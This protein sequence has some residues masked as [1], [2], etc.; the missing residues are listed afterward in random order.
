VKYNLWDIEVAR[1]LGHFEDEREALARVRLLLDQHGDEYAAELALGRVTDE[2]QIL[3]P[4][5]GTL[6]LARVNELLAHG[7]KRD[8]Q[9]D[10]IIASPLR[11]TNP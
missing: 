4:L 8:E 6:L 5:T 9:G 2:G 7:E 3:D 11:S 10:V 1:Y